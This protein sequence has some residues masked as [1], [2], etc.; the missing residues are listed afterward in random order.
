M[1]GFRNRKSK[2]GKSKTGQTYQAKHERRHIKNYLTSR[3][4]EHPYYIFTTEDQGIIMSI[5]HGMNELFITF[6]YNYNHERVEL[7]T[8]EKMQYPH[9]RNGM[10]FTVQFEERSANLVFAQL[11]LEHRSGKTKRIFPIQIRD[12]DADLAPISVPPAPPH[13]SPQPPTQVPAYV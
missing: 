2:G 10:K 11:L 5:F 4:S 8:Q 6:Y 13:V 12:D 1:K 7:L 9:H 3:H